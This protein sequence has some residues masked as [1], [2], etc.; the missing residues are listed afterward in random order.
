MTHLSHIRSVADSIGSLSLD[1]LR[2]ELVRTGDILVHQLLPHAEHEDQLLYA[3]LVN[4]AGGLTT[5]ALLR[6]DHVELKALADEFAVIPLNAPLSDRAANDLR[7]ILY[8]IH[9][10]LKLHFA[11]EEQLYMSF[12]EE[13]THQL[14]D[15]SQLKG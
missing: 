10:I 3:A 9:A 14:R 7:R 8:S 2:Q 13:H 12:L 5:A 1:Q 15:N 6:P 4:N 11:K